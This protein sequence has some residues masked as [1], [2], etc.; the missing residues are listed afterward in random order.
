M[1]KYKQATEASKQASKGMNK[2]MG[3]RKSKR[4]E[5]ASGEQ[6]KH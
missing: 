3:R 1:G 4:C 2:L 5:R 6:G